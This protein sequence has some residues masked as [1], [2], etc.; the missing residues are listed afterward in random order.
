MGICQTAWQNRCVIGDIGR[1]DLVS[2]LASMTRNDEVVVDE[3]GSRAPLLRGRDPGAPLASM[4]RCFIHSRPSFSFIAFF[5]IPCAGAC[6]C[7][8]N[9]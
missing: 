6:R 3:L 4:T 1:A 7:L 8:Q 5:A 2:P 9:E